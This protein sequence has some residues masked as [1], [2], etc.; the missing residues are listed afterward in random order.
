MKSLLALCSLLWLIVLPAHAGEEDGIVDDPRVSLRTIEPARDV[1]Y[2][3]GDKITRTVILEVDQPF[4][5]LPTSLP[6]AGTQKKR[7]NQEQGIETH[8]VKVEKSTHAG[9]NVYTLQLTYQ[10]FTRG[11]TAKPA[12]LPPEFVK[13]GGKGENF[14]VRIPSWNFRISPLAVFGDVV[15][16]KDMSGYR[17]PL[18]LDAAPAWRLLWVLLGICALSLLGLL[19]ILGSRR[20]L[21]RMGGPFARAGRD[22]NKLP[23]GDAG[24]RQGVARLHAAFN[25]SA[26]GTVF[27][28]AGFLRRK[29]GFAPLADDIGRFFALSRA[30]YFDPSAAHGIAG[31]PL[32][33]LRGFCRRCRDCERGLK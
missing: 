3:V 29:P 11:V 2:S 23:T 1:G 28:A 17:G 8:A 19:Y 24:L 13:F 16:E 15:V 25:A 7:Q 26:G 4:E 27:D 10:V 22:L 30:V 6:V 12:A 18:L 20:W 32:A 9:K 31:D 5:L 33:W 21:P 14:T